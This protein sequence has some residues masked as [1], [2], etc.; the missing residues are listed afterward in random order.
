MERGNVTVNASSMR[1]LVDNDWFDL[2]TNRLVKS[3]KGAVRIADYQ[4]KA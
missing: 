4:H 1:N 2:L 3:G